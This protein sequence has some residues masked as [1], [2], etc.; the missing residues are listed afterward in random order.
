[1]TRIFQVHSES[2]GS[3]RL[4]ILEFTRVSKVYEERVLESTR[5]LE[6]YRPTFDV[7]TT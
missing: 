7:V 6:G 4:R 5:V 1:M 3:V 2:F